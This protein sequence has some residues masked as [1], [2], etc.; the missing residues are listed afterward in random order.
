MSKAHKTLLSH[1]SEKSSISQLKPFVLFVQIYPAH[2]KFIVCV[3]CIQ[4][5]YMYIK[6][7]SCMG[8]LCLNKSY[9][10]I[11][12]YRRNSVLIS[13]YSNDDWPPCGGK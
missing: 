10:A 8:C 3:I 1:L 13:Q 9:V 6:N 12:S 4:H 11:S 7:L 5:M 2:T